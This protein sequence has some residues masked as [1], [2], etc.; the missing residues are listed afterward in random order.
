MI[1]ALS[2]V[3]KLIWGI[4]REISDE[5]AYERHL[6]I[7]GI[8]KSAATWRAFQDEKAKLRYQKPKCC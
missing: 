1:A 4:A 3:L 5:A 6:S 8:P 7:K 2:N